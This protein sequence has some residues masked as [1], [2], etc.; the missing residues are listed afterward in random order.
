MLREENV[1][2]TK[3][4]FLTML[5]ETAPGKTSLKRALF[6]WD[7]EGVYSTWPLSPI[8]IRFLS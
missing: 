6:V 4:Y 1:E 7:I 8:F 5:N 2:W 3:I